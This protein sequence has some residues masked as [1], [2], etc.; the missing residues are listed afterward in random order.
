MIPTN[1]KRINEREREREK[2][3]ERAYRLMKEAKRR[4]VCG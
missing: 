2:E 1:R 3:R 4:E